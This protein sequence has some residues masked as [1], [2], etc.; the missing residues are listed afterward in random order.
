[1]IVIPKPL[2]GRYF[3][4]SQGIGN[5]VLALSLVIGG[6]LLTIISARTMAAAAGLVHIG[7]GLIFALAVLWIFELG[8]SNQE[9]EQ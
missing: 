1:M 7:V 3:A 9:E 8:A 2:R 6:L 5:A 4:F